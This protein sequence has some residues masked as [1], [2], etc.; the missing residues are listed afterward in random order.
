MGRHRIGYQRQGRF[1]AIDVVL[2]RWR[3]AHSDRPDNFSAHVNRQP[4]PI[5]AL[6]VAP[7]ALRASLGTLA[8]RSVRERSGVHQVA[9][10]GGVVTR[11]V[12]LTDL[13]QEGE[14]RRLRLT[15]DDSQLL[16]P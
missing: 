3:P 11:D 9:K 2:R 7:A 16:W 10:I 15:G 14:R 4:P 13:R 8:F 6:Y 1:R 5:L 12:P